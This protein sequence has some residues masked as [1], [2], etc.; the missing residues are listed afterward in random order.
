MKI[1]KKILE[2]LIREE[3]Q[4][5]LED[6]T[7]GADRM[8]PLL[9]VSYTEIVTESGMEFLVVISKDGKEVARGLTSDLNDAADI[10]WKRLPAMQVPRS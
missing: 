4:T 7:K 3:L 9:T 1:T 10:A 5:L 8:K 6:P 2:N